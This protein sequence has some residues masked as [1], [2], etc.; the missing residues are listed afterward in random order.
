MFSSRPSTGP[1]ETGA[2]NVSGSKVASKISLVEDRKEKIPFR[3]QL[4]VR[5]LLHLV[6]M[7]SPKCPRPILRLIAA[8]CRYK[9]ARLS[10]IK[11]V[12]GI[13]LQQS[14]AVTVLDSLPMSAMQ[15]D[16]N[17]VTSTST[18]SRLSGNDT[19]SFSVDTAVILSH[20][21]AGLTSTSLRRIIYCIS[22]L[23]R[24]T[25]NLVWYDVMNRD[26]E[27]GETLIS[28]M[29][30]TTSSEWIFE[31]L[32]NLLRFTSSS[33]DLDSVLQ[34][35]E[36]ICNPL[37]KLTVVQANELYAAA[38]SAKLNKSIEA[39]T[40]PEENNEV[41]PTPTSTD[42][43]PKSPSRKRRSKSSDSTQST[44]SSNAAAPAFAGTEEAQV[45]TTGTRHPAFVG[46][47]GGPVMTTGTLTD[48]SIMNSDDIMSYPRFDSA[49][50]KSIR[51]YCGRHVGDEGYHNTCGTCDGRCGPTGLVFSHS[52]SLF[53]YI[54]YTHARTRMRHIS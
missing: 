12:V 23:L 36:S 8:C 25:D 6:T 5:L 38:R 37:S 26:R 47:A 29:A 10:I 43:E 2:T 14:N 11:A 50:T 30:S 41:A 51:H 39:S 33:V 22:Y 15:N 1:Q 54:I 31:S 32:L 46:A 7:K 48:G 27:D 13:A 20:M 44:R 45:W 16:I 34:L 35:L 53:I 42:D 17:G 49:H 18:P 24:K 52:L 40:S 21:S 3:R 9:S 28:S 19:T 4:V